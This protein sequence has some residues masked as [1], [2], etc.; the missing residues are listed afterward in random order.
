MAFHLGCLRA[1]H[2]LGLLRRVRVMSTISGGSV[3]GAYFA[4]T[5]HLSFEQ[6]DEAVCAL[7]GSGLQTRIAIEVLRPSRILHSAAAIVALAF[8]HKSNQDGDTGYKWS[9]TDALHTVLQ[10][11]L[12]GQL[13]MSAPRRSDMDIVI[14]ACELRRGTAFRF[15][16]TRAGDWRHGELI[17]WDVEVG[18][19]AAA[20]AAYPLLL[21][22][23]DRVWRFRHKGTEQHHRVLLTDGGVYDNLGLQV[24]E[25]GRDS[26][27][28]LHTF[29][30]DYLIACNA[31]QGQSPGVVIPTTLIP[32]LSRSFEIVH[33]R[34]QDSAMAR[35]HAL[36]ATGALKGFV[37]PYLGQIDGSLPIPPRDLV[38]RAE[39]IDYPTDFAPMPAAWI[40][41]LSRRGEQLTRTLIEFYLPRIL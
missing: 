9:R 30:C 12:F 13:R 29:Q 4:Y 18:F 25:P 35:L 5:P 31:G 14:G 28:S 37:L 19:A 17:T 1:L 21:P 22:A 27:F 39:V 2:D 36:R 15:G 7:L 38:P 16:N 11:Q 10:R 8:L 20:S 26:A 24:L 23:L 34:V 6:F 41:R 40:D 32:R 3:I 33:R